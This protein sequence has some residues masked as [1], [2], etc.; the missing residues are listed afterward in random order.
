MGE[1]DLQADELNLELK[2]KVKDLSQQIKED[3]RTI[4]KDEHKDLT[5]KFEM[6]LD[7]LEALLKGTIEKKEAVK[8]NPVIKMLNAR[9]VGA[10]GDAL[11]MWDNTKN[12]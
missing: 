8:A 6:K 5:E 11:S 3:V 7:R 12:T 10:N 2:T 4:I 9:P 1:A